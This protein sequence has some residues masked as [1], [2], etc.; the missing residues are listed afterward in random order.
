MFVNKFFA[1]LVL[2]VLLF[3]LIIAINNEDSDP[4]FNNKILNDDDLMQWN[5]QLIP[6]EAIYIQASTRTQNKNFEPNSDQV[7]IGHK[8]DHI[9]Q[10]NDWLFI[11]ILTGS[12]LAG[13]IILVMV[14]IC[15]I[16]FS[17]KIKKPST[18]VEYG[19]KSSATG[20]NNLSAAESR[21]LAQSAQMFHYQHQKQQMIDMEKATNDAK[22]DSTDSS[23]HESESDGDYSVYEC[24]GL[25]PAGDLEV[26]NPLFDEY[27][28]SSQNL[29]PPPYT[30]ISSS[31]NRVVEPTATAS[32]SSASASSSLEHHTEVKDKVEN[33]NETTS[34]NKD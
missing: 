23:D 33:V 21:R 2:Q 17:K 34:G 30:A 9:K 5:S 26:K 7:Q 11:V 14:S 25:A 10:Q 28:S 27:S 1:I 4:F 32:S 12:A 22:K 15:W 18:N 24:P 20:K 6:G 31:A 3:D 16:A 19:I 13:V 29:S 8:I